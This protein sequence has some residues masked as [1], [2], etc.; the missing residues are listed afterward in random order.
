MSSLMIHLLAAYK[1]DSNASIDF[2]IG[3]VAPDAVSDRESKDKTHFRDQDDRM[4]ALLDFAK[5]YDKDNDFVKGVLL[6]L[7][8]DYHW[9]IGPQ[10]EHYMNYQ[11]DNWITDYRMEIGI[12]SAWLFHQKPWGEPMFRN[13]VSYKAKFP[14]GICGLSIDAVSSLLA[15]N[16]RWHKDL[17]PEPSPYFSPDLIEEFTSRI[18]HNFRDWYDSLSVENTI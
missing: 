5:T 9:D 10:K 17:N 12:A 3:N 8:L 1:Y 13:M 14:E 15:R 6:H 7:F 18:A 11:G 2:F 4:Q 16:Y